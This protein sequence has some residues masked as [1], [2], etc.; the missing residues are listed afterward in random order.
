MLTFVK[1]IG[2]IFDRIGVPETSY[3]HDPDLLILCFE[4]SV[5]QFC[6]FFCRRFIFNGEGCGYAVGDFVK[7]SV[8]YTVPFLRGILMVFF[9]CEVSD[10]TAN[11]TEE[12]IRSLRRYCIP[13]SEISVVYA[14]FGIESVVQYVI[15]DLYAFIAVFI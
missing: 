7:S 10:D 1:K 8:I 5:D 2:K 13:D 15:C 3:K 4:K 11:I 14:F 9:E 6:N 12:R